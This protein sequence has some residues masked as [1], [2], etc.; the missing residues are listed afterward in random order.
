MPF[1]ELLPCPLAGF[2]LSTYIKT[3]TAMPLSPQDKGEVVI[4]I[5]LI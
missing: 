1:E 2:S 3:V 4:P 5:L